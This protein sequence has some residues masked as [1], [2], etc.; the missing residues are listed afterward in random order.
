MTTVGKSTQDLASSE[1]LM[2]VMM[3]ID[4]F[5][6]EKT[7]DDMG[8]TIATM[9]Q[10]EPTDFDRE[11]YQ[12]GMRELIGTEEADRLLSSVTLTGQFKRFP[13]KLEQNL[14]I[15][16]LNMRWN[17]ATD[18]YQSA[19]LIGIGNIG[20]RQVNLKING[21]VEIVVGRIP[22]INI[23]L[24]ADKDTWYYFKYSRNIM[25]AFSSVEEFNSNITE[26]K[27]DKRKMKVE[28]GEAPYTFMIGSKRLKDD[29]IAKF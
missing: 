9:A 1:V 7:I 15:T 11:G 25:K 6:D 3:L 23:Y 22:E 21:K 4:F 12:I 13:E 8:K 27:T 19:G 2:N 17:P 26:L 24:E 28:R 29:F 20:K 14:F 18:S 10:G 5:F 16:D